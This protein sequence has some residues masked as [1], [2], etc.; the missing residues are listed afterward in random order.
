VPC[1]VRTL[2][3]LA[4]AGVAGAANPDLE[5]LYRGFQNPPPQYSISPYWFWNGRITAPETRR[6]IG[7]MVSQGVHAV[8]VM[9]WAGLEPAYLSEDY[10][11]PVGAALEAARSAGLSLNFSDEFLW[12]SGQVWDRASLKTEPSRVLQLHPEYRMRRLAVKRLRP[13]PFTLDAV[14]EVVVAARMGPSGEIDEQSLTVIPAR[15]RLDWKAPGDGWTLF[16]YTP[17]VATE[18]G[19]RT[20]LLNPAAVQVFI[21]LV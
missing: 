7:E 16:V 1:H 18:R 21:D 20:D 6:Q 10:Y 19:V 13:A 5:A 12:P 2:L 9:N 17:V 14:P 4:L 8:T 15:R 11:R 3:L